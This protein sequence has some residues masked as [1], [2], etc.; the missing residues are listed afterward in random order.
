MRASVVRFGG[1]A[2]LPFLSLLIPFLALP[3]IARVA[4]TQEWAALG[5]GESLGAIVAIVVGYGWPLVGPARVASAHIDD[6]RGH[7][8]VSTSSRMLVFVLISVPAGVV[9]AALSPDGGQA[10]GVLSFV[11]T[12]ILGL[13]PAWFLIGRG[14]PRALA[15]YETIPRIAAGLAAILLVLAT[16]QVLWY[17]ILMIAVTAG[18]Q[19]LF[20]ARH[21]ASIV[22]TRLEPWR[23]GLT[24]LRMDWSPAVAVLAGGA[25]SAATV[26]LVS[27]V[28]SVAV[29]AIFV[30]AD[31]L[32][33]ASLTAI[34][35]AAN[36]LQGW[37]AEPDESGPMRRRGYRGLGILA[38]VGFVGALGISLFGPLATQ[39]LFGLD[40]AIDTPT[41]LSVGVAFL[42]IA[43]NTAI[44][45]L[46]LV[47][48][49]AVRWVTWSTIAG[50]VIGVPTIIAATAAF[51]VHGA[52]LAFAASE[53]L[54]V[55]VQAGAL[56]SIT[57]RRPVDDPE[58]Q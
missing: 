21:G 34:V 39:I 2:A 9:A 25:Y 57:L 11:S 18:F 44:G 58:A 15:I 20:A 29:V 48:M 56:V 54:V 43:L 33:K 38:G 24:Q 41:A 7:L 5:I 47:P 28:G 42:A 35:S 52:A 1:L 22:L 51:G 6:A 31:K 55:T 17:P 45:R 16:G 27:T 30:S 10:L 53:V 46:L 40:L 26:A 13:S 32:L 19:V 49:G 37:V 23:M 3:V 8:V 36:A 12:A 4:T 50:A 14:D